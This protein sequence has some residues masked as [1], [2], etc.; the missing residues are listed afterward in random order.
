M[1]PNTNLDPPIKTFWG[2]DSGK[3]YP[4]ALRQRT[5]LLCGDESY[6]K[7]GPKVLFASGHGQLSLTTTRRES[8]A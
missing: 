1:Q 4:K 8:I 6:F 2:D 3:V 7:Q 5:A